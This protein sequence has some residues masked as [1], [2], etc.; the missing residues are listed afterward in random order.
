MNNFKAITDQ[1]AE[2]EWRL[3]YTNE[4]PPSHHSFNEYK[5][6][7]Q[8]YGFETAKYGTPKFDSETKQEKVRN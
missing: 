7:K 3:M 6:F 2:R 8:S 4:L 1:I 5:Q